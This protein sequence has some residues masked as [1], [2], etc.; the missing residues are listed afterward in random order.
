MRIL[1]VPVEVFVSGVCSVR[2]VTPGLGG[3]FMYGLGLVCRSRCCVWLLLER[4]VLLSIAI[5]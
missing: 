1:P 4:V 2:C 3:V 5:R